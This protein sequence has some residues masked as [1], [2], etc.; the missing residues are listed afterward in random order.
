[1]SNYTG[2]TPETKRKADWRDTAACRTEDPEMFFPTGTEGGWKLV[3]NDAKSVCARCPS[4]TDCLNFA[5]DEGISDGIFG[6]LTE[7]ERAAVRRRVTAKQITREKAAAQVQQAEE[8]GPRTLRSIWNA[9]AHPLGDGHV[10]WRGRP[11]VY[12]ESR[13][14]TPRQLSFLLDRGRHPE[15]RVLATCG[16]NTCVMPS[17]LGDDRERTRC[18]TRPGYQRHLKNGEMPCADCRQANADAD[19]RLR[20]T[21]T[22]R[23][24]VIA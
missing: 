13:S 2:S 17:H 24:K 11:Q 6:G 15:G 20:R 16:I 21:G 18:G 9:K 7:K 10:I 5:L 8:S 14:Y 12:F 3:I 1:M 19:N 22:T 23:Q 4:R